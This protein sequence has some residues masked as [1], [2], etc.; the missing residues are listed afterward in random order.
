MNQ[1]YI[2]AA[3]RGLIIGVL[4]GASAFFATWSQTDEVKVLVSAAAV[5]AITTWL[6]FLGYGAIDAHG[7]S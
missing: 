6:G 1:A 4:V 5:P 2:V 7:K 3:T